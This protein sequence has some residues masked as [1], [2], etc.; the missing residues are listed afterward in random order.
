MKNVTRY[1]YLI[2]FCLVLQSD[3]INFVNFIRSLVDSNDYVSLLLKTGN[4][5]SEEE[6]EEGEKEHKEKE[7]KNIKY[8]PPF[9]FLP[10]T[11]RIGTFR[12]PGD[13]KL[14]SL[15]SDTETPPPKYILAV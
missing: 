3:T 8:I 1:I 14:F 13:T 15:T 12:R 2:L 11:K 5:T 4:T 9:V 7:F 10:A 6:T